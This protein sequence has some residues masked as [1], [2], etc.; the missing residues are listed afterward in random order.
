MQSEALLR[1]ML[2][3][4]TN[5][6]QSAKGRKR[7]QFHKEFIWQGILFSELFIG[8]SEFAL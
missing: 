4:D 2:L 8:S 5:V 3:G 7:P 1:V 6:H